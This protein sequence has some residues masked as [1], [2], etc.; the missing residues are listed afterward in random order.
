MTLDTNG[1]IATLNGLIE[2]CED[3]AKGFRTAA[4]GV[5]SSDA[6]ALFQGRVALIEQ[7]A[8]TLRAEVRRLGGDPENRG[9]LAGAIHRGWIDLKAAITGK[10]DAAIIAECE[11]GEDV[12]VKNYEAAMKA[13]LPPEIRT[14][15]DRQ[16]QGVLQNRERVR[17]LKHS[18]ASGMASR[19][20]DA[21]R[22]APPPA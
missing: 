15:V 3:G 12:A 20:R 21:D 14:M 5:K 13:D 1:I 4:E 9:T 18:S 19:S 2:T 10:D 22:G 8:G 17:A 6:K 11:R 7:A 16:Y